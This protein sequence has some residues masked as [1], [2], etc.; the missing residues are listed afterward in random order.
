[1]LKKNY[2]IILA[3]VLFFCC[4]AMALDEMTK[5]EYFDDLKIK[6]SRLKEISDL[7]KDSILLKDICPDFSVI[8]KEMGNVEQLYQQKKLTAL[9][10]KLSSLNKKIDGM[11]EK[12]LGKLQDKLS[13][14]PIYRKAT[15]S[16]LINPY[17]AMA[18]IEQ[19]DKLTLDI[20]NHPMPTSQNAKYHGWQGYSKQNVLGKIEISTDSLLQKVSTALGLDYNLSLT[21]IDYDPLV[22]SARYIDGAV[23]FQILDGPGILISSKNFSMAISFDKNGA[24]F[25]NN[26]WYKSKSTGD[27]KIFCGIAFEGQSTNCE[28]CVIFWADT[29]EELIA[30]SAHFRDFK[31][32]KYKTA[33]WIQSQTKNFK[34]QGNPPSLIKQ[35]ETSKRVL[36]SMQFVSGGI[37]AAPDNG[38][39]AI[40]VR[41]TANAVI[42]PALCGDL[43]YLKRWTP[44]LMN[45]PT[46]VDYKGKKYKSFLQFVPSDQNQCWQQDGTF[47]SIL[48]AYS[49][50]KLTADDSELAKWYSLGKGAI[51][52]INA[53][54]Y[55]EEMGLY[56]EW[57]INEA[58]MKIAHDWENATNWNPYIKAM[59]IDDRWPMYMYTIY[60]NNNLYNSFIMLAEMAEEL[61]LEKDKDE[62]LQRADKLAKSIDEHLYDNENKRYLPGI[63]Q[64][65][66]GEKIPVDFNYWDIYFDYVWAFTLHPQAS[67][68][69]KAFASLD[70][71]LNNRNGI[72]PGLDK[73]LYFS[74]ARPHASYVYS[75]MGQFDKAAICLQRI[76]ERAEDINLNQPRDV[77][78][79][80]KGA[81]PERVDRVSG[82]RPQTFTAGPYLYGAASLGFIMDYH[83]ITICPSGYITKAENI[84]M[85][86]SVFSI[87]PTYS[88]NPG[89]LIFDKKKIPYSLKL[90]SKYNKPGKHSISILDTEKPIRPLLEYTCFELMDIKT[91]AKT[92]VYHLKGFG[93]GILRFDS[94]VGK[95]CVSVKNGSSDMDFRFWKDNNSSFVQINSK[96]KFTA[97]VKRN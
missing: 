74:P 44:Y 78:Y 17:M 3:I 20:T 2:L 7:S 47:Y 31:K 69:Q 45:N 1:M 16:I 21:S 9:K 85:V 90:P 23:D 26:F 73:K 4:Q 97:S 59:K 79:A 28:N 86:D 82:H 6:V 48:S 34:L 19:H 43:Q 42:F 46:T 63:A 35:V 92:V 62:F 67:D 60:I 22:T 41:D 91:K 12:F 68:P 8:S 71:M 89:G 72:F 24:E 51:E 30:I 54:A 88:K 32:I 14:T 38:Y 81:I 61:K 53:S 84:C 80:M 50:W 18:T 10:E 64:M 95:D 77:I 25:K 56:Y 65:E 70:N 76:T 83:G 87:D 40:W 33:K 58:P 55:D 39:D 57:Y 52:F 49:Y 29:L 94:S 93:N 15:R 5:F 11:N 37:Y 66:E 36:L 75:A 27:V 96:G 13:P